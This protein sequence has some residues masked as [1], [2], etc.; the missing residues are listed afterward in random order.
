VE[1]FTVEGMSCG[2]CVNT[3]TKAVH[4]VDLVARVSAD[5]ATRKVD[6][7]S[8]VSRDQLATAIKNA[9]YAVSERAAPTAYAK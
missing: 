5:L 9:G 7:E 4:D 8:A 6:I 1:T 3:V 2:H